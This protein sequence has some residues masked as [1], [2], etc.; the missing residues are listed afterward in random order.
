MNGEWKKV[1]LGE[2]A[3]L[4]GMVDG[5]FGSNLP[6]SDYTNFGVPI[7]RGN[8]LSLG[9]VKFIDNGYKYV[10]ERTG[11]LFLQKKVH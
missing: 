10:S 5:P 9:K 6:A 2:I 11:I 4:K 7:I 1:K 8:N 3:T